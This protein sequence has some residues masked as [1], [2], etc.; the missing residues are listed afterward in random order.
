MRGRFI[1]FIGAALLT[2]T[3]HAQHGIGIQG[4]PLF[5]QGLSEQATTALSN[6]SGYTVGF[7]FVE[8]AQGESGF[9]IGLELCRS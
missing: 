4:G 8:G 2:A 9:R 5:F 6:T 1:T 7:Q 3:G